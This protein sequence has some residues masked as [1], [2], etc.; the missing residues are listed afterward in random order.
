MHMHSPAH[1]PTPLPTHT[2]YTQV[3]DY[4]A[5]LRVAQAIWFCFVFAVLGFGIRLRFKLAKQQHSLIQCTTNRGQQQ[6]LSKLFYSSLLLA[7]SI[8]N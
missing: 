8:Y 2:H 1:T 3:T 6:Q 5:T 4:D 7:V